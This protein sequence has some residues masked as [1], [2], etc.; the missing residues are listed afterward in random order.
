MKVKVL[1]WIGKE[2]EHSFHVIHV[3]SM[4]VHQGA[5][6]DKGELSKAYNEAIMWHRQSFNITNST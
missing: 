3:S 1:L 4:E 6:S 2:A 5:L